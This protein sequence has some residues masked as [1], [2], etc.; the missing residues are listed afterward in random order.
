M[1]I[2]GSMLGRKERGQGTFSQREIDII[3]EVFGVS[4]SEFVESAKTYGN[5]DSIPV[6]HMATAGGSWDHGENQ[7]YDG[8]TAVERVDR[9]SVRHPKAFGIRVTG[10]S[11]HPSVA[12]GDLL[13]CEPVE[14]EDE[15]PRL[16][17]GRMVVVT[18]RDE[19]F[20]DSLQVGRWVWRNPKGFRLNKDNPKY[21]AQDYEL[22]RDRV[23][24]LAVVVQ[25]RRDNP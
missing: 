9:G 4:A 3:S 17:S 25:V 8:A 23:A 16:V 10:D 1:G 11:M 6:I 2:T 24:R 15:L 14:F 5:V 13:I 12:A 19:R 7:E 20:G 22:E 21:P 18:L